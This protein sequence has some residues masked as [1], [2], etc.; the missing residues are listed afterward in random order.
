MTFEGFTA[1]LAQPAPA[2]ELSPALSALWW[3]VKGNW[4]RAHALV[5]DGTG[6]E[7]AWV[8]AHLHRV[9]GDLG[10]ADYWYRRA[11]KRPSTAPLAAERETLI[12]ALLAA[13]R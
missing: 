5:N 10:N 13:E 4:E 11:G 7:E 6:A 1:S 3:M 12:K 2:A 9:E 8:H